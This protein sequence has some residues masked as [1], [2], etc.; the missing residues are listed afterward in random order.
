MNKAAINTNTRVFVQTL[1]FIYQVT[2]QDK[3]AELYIKYTFNFVSTVFQSGWTI[4]LDHQQFI[5]IPIP[6]YFSNTWY[7]QCFFSLTILIGMQYQ[8]TL[9]LIY[10]SLVTI[11]I[12]HDFMCLYAN[13]VNLW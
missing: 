8:N 13:Y 5:G 10:I 3:M 9:V 11:D 4:W 2:I 6:P 1:A 12:K 7:G